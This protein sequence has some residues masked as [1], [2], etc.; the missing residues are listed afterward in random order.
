MEQGS[1]G[2]SSVNNCV[3]K[4]FQRFLCTFENE[5]LCESIFNISSACI[6]EPNPHLR[7]NLSP[8]QCSPTSSDPIL[9]E[10]CVRGGAREPR[11][12]TPKQDAISKP[13]ALALAKIVEHHP[14]TQP[15]KPSADT[16]QR[17]RIATSGLAHLDDNQLRRLLQ[18][19]RRRLSSKHINDAARAAKHALTPAETDQIL[20]LLGRIRD[21]LAALRQPQNAEKD[22]SVILAASAGALPPGF[23]GRPAAGTALSQMYAELLGG[24]NKGHAVRAALSAEQLDAAFSALAAAA[25]G[26]ATPPS[27]GR[28]AALA[29]PRLPAD[30]RARIAELDPPPPGS[31]GAAPPARAPPALVALARVWLGRG[32]GSAAAP[33]GAAPPAAAT[34]PA[35]AIP[36]DAGRGRSLSPAP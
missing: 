13:D 4:V 5:C 28:L 17:A 19:E 29:L 25:V 15:F 6:A 11:R 1:L 2:G 30:V 3:H 12:R 35:P 31:A 16:L 21:E 14:A 32:G 36:A 10:Q 9:K 7:I 27:A 8:L 22:W 18:Q 23:P 24:K 26:R 34:C 33:D 20:R